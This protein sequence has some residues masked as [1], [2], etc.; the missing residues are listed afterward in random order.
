LD[1]HAKNF[2]ESVK[3]N[4]PSM[5]N[6]AIQTGS[7]AAINAQM[8]NIAYKTGKKVYW[9]ADKNQFTDK[10]A[11]RLIKADYHNGWELPKI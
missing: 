10:E 4:D 6:C 2:I 5:L 7:I 11:N 8:G 3:A 1:H 9:N